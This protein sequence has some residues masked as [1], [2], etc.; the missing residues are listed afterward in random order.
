MSQSAAHDEIYVASAADEWLAESQAN[1]AVFARRKFKAG[2]L[3][4]LPFNHNLVEGTLTRP[5]GA[6]PLDMVITPDGE[7]A[8]RVAF[9]VKP[10]WQPKRTGNL[11]AAIVPFWLLAK[12]Q[13]GCEPRLRG[14]AASQGSLIYAIAEV[15]VPSPAAVLKGGR[16][17][18]SK[19]TMWVPYLTNDMSLDK[20]ARLLVKGNMPAA[21]AQ[22]QVDTAIED[23]TV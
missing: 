17:C 21:W 16:D 7:K 20:G 13:Q 11:I 6:V 19:V 14:K 5:L 12:T 1:L 8:T 2:E 22:T 10:L 9:W 15:D 23:D 4:L 3:V 18:K